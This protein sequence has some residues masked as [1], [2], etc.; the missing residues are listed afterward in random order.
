MLK[1]MSFTSS[2]PSH[3][4]IRWHV[5]FHYLVTLNVLMED[6]RGLHFYAFSPFQSGAFVHC[7]WLICTKVSLISLNRLIFNVWCPKLFLQ[8]GLW[9][10]TGGAA[11]SGFQ[12]FM[13]LPTPNPMCWVFKHQGRCQGL[14]VLSAAQYKA[15]LKVG[16]QH[17][18]AEWGIFLGKSKWFGVRRPLSK[19][20]F[21][22]VTLGKSTSLSLSFLFCEVGMCISHRAD[23]RSKGGW[24]RKFFVNC[25]GTCTRG[26]FLLCL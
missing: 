20:W 10:L 2:I 7:L 22:Y 1:G 3:S 23:I 8:G 9:T 19:S 17:I 14:P 24:E 16:S 21:N 26:L 4:G 11:T 13:S 5:P 6:I 18:F 25:K 15:R 12:W